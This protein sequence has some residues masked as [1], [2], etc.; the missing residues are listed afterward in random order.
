MLEE[1]TTYLNH[2]GFGATPKKVLEAAAAWRHQM[3]AEPVRFM[4]EELMPALQDTAQ[5]LAKYLGADVTGLAFVDNATTGMNAVLQSIDLRPGDELVTSNHAY[6]AVRTTLEFVCNTQSAELKLADIPFPL[7]QDPISA[8]Q[9]ILDA[10][11]HTLSSRTR[12]LVI[13]HVTSHTAIHLPLMDILAMARDRNIPVLVDGA[14]GPGNLPLEMRAYVAAG[15]TWYVGN[16][17]KWLCSAKSAGFLW[18]HPDWRG[19]VRPPVIGNTF[20]DGYSEAFLWPGT[21]DFSPWL[22]VGAALDFQHEFGAEIIRTYCHKLAAEAAAMLADRWSSLRGAPADFASAMTTIAIPLDLPPTKQSAQ[23]VYWALRHDH[24]V[25]AL[26]VA[27]NGRLWCRISAY[28]YNEISDY[29]RLG[30]AMIALGTALE[31]TAGSG[32][33]LPL[34]SGG[35][36]TAA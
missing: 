22:A 13:D 34:R 23:N 14:H 17:H 11:E 5:R 30:D 6:Q 29:V 27:F 35:Q 8:K 21:R 24:G 33:R 15:L 12:L 4:E 25:E 36:I 16:C 19:S 32:A 1:G 31:S 3:E 10:I 18:T 28:L 20:G 7:S 9:E 26:V 2:A